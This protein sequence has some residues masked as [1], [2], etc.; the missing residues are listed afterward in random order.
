MSCAA[1]PPYVPTPIVNASSL[2]WNP[3]ADTNVTAVVIHAYVGTAW[4]QAVI[5]PMPQ[6]VAAGV[7]TNWPS[8]TAFCATA[9]N[10]ATGA[11]SLPSNQVTNNITAI[12][13][14]PAA[15][16]KQ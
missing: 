12:P 10:S 1:A 13:A 4:Q 16:T 14:S 3:I 6:T 11:E 5:I 7:L 8:G 2:A 15:L 9:T